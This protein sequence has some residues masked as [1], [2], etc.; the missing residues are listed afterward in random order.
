[1]GSTIET[2]SLHGLP[3]LP[4]IY[5]SIK[6]SYSVKKDRPVKGAYQIFCTAYF[7]A[8][9]NEPVITQIDMPFSIEALPVPPILYKMIY[10]YIKK[11]LDPNYGTAQQSLVFSDDD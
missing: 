7:S 4:N 2:Y 9:K 5:F 1:M 8:S 11:Q 10:D 6:G 3:P